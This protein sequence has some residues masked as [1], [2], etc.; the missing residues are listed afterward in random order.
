MVCEAVLQSDLVTVPE[1][2]ALALQHHQAGRLAEAEAIYRQILAADPRHADAMHLLGVIAHQVGRNDVA[3]EM[4]L[5]AI[6][7]AP[8]NPAF[9]SNLGEPYR[10]LGR[11]DD[12]IAAYRR[13]IELK[14]D[15]AKFHNNLGNVL[16]ALSRFDE[17]I[18]ACRRAIQLEPDYAEPYNNLGAALAE[19][20]RF[21]EAVAA[22]HRVIQLKP[23]YAEAHSNLGNTLTPLGRLDE[24]IAAY[25]RAIQLKPDFAEAHYNLGNA[26]KDQGDLDDAIATYH[27]AIQLNP[28][29]A[30]AYT[31]MGV[32]LKDQGYLGQAIAAFRHALRLRPDII[33]AH[34]NLL[35]ALHYPDNLDAGEIF[36]EH[37]RWDE[38]HA[39]PRAKFIMPHPNEA[40]PKRRL[41]VGYF[42]SD[43]REHS[44]ALFMEGLLANHDP[45]QFEMFYYA[46]LFSADPV[47]ERLREH[48]G[49]CCKT[50]AMTDAQVAERIRK[51]GIDILVDLAGHTG[52]SRLLVFARK[53]A[54]VQVT[55]LGYCDTTGM[56][57]MDYRL[58][59]ALADPPGTTKHLHTEQLVRLPDSAWCF[60]PSDAAPPVAALPALHSGHITFGCFNVLPK[61]TEEFLALWS[62]ILLQVPGSRLLLKNSSFR[63]PTVQ[64]RM[65]ALLEKNGVTPERVELVATVPTLAE[66]LALY[67]RLDIALDPFPYHGTTTTCEALWQGV[68]VVTLAGRTHVSRVGVSLLSNVGLA[69][70]VA[71]SPEE[72]VKT[73]VALAANVSRLAELRSTM[74]ERMAASPLM[75]APRFARNV[76]HAYREMWRAWCAKPCSNPTS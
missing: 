6:A 40:N 23:D 21:D 1:A 53:P 18:A 63:S 42:S 51:D 9:H 56:C 66:H 15:D 65:R 60:R 57:A 48:M 74:R 2:L 4:I 54:P 46:E 11:L 50:T 58:T 16:R 29:Y 34:S 20:G 62:Q 36:Q 41:R 69:E 24:A 22:F 32:A 37:C 73:A 14:P 27:R 61:I 35:L 55:Y 12:A 19:Q 5:K 10:Q 70:L 76:E 26:L 25:R 30:A 13:A 72:Y 7:L 17:A 8:A 49:S 3:V 64:Q 31:N 28:D 43:L 71:H 47:T 52:H 68:P 59:D 44:L 38:V 39:L 67:G 45:A 33:V 75:D